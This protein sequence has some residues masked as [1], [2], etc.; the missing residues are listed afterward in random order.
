MLLNSPVSECT[1]AN[2]VISNEEELCA[3]WRDLCNKNKYS[4]PE[5]PRAFVRG[6]VV[7]ISFHSIQHQKQQQRS[8]TFVSGTQPI[9]F[10]PESESHSVSQSRCC[11][12]QSMGCRRRHKMIPHINRLIPHDWTRCALRH[13]APFLHVQIPSSSHSSTSSLPSP[14]VATA[15]AVLIRWAGVEWRGECWSLHPLIR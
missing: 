11:W 14:V 3:V 1:T 4:G 9:E 15:A 2:N 6:C 8:L 7:D 13:T 12:H 10:Y 5:L